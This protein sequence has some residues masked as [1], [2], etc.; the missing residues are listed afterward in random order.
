MMRETFDS[1]CSRLMF[2]SKR[3]SS[4]GGS[5]GGAVGTGERS[6]VRASEISVSARS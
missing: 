5:L 3:I 6:A 2:D 4:L 1:N